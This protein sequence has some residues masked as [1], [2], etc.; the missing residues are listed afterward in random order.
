MSL[1]VF[2]TLRGGVGIIFFHWCYEGRLSII[3]AALH[4][5]TRKVKVNNLIVFKLVPNCPWQTY[6]CLQVVRLFVSVAGDCSV[7]WHL[8]WMDTLLHCPQAHSQCFQWCMLN[9]GISNWLVHVIVRI[10]K[11]HTVQYEVM[12][13][14]NSGWSNS[15][16][17]PP[18][19]G[20]HIRHTPATTPAHWWWSWNQWCAQS[21]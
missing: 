1:P 14:T 19:P 12:Q 20:M 2:S 4:E 9:L 15:F 7:V 8:I 11:E 18:I 16:P 17:P 5:I 10:W 6:I 13:H 3:M 21:S